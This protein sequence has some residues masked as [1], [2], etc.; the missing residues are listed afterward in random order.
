MVARL[1]RW[2]LYSL[3]LPFTP[4]A[5]IDWHVHQ[6]SRLFSRGPPLAAAAAKTKQAPR[7]PVKPVG[8]YMSSSLKP[9]QYGFVGGH[10]ISLQ[11]PVA[12]THPTNKSTHAGRKNPMHQQWLYWA[13][14]FSW[15]LLAMAWRI[16]WMLCHKVGSVFA[17]Q[18]QLLNQ[19]YTFKYD[20]RETRKDKFDREN[21][22]IHLRFSAKRGEKG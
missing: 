13:V 15:M 7:T 8:S 18:M 17:Q 16:Q 6:S 3:S 20:W 14:R 22:N 2:A 21:H 11:Q 5:G 10:M 9:N 19:V 1:G 4:T 12:C